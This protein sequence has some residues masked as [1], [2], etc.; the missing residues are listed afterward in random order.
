MSAPAPTSAHAPH[1]E[2]GCERPRKSRGSHP[3]SRGGRALLALLLGGVLW[4]VAAGPASAHATL[5]AADPPDG[6]RLDRSPAQIHLTF[7]EHVSASLGGVRVVDS[8][9]AR[10]DRGAVRA[11]GPDVVVDVQ[12]DLPDGTYV[13]TYR[14]VSADG[15]PVRGSTLFAVGSG[16]VDPSVAARAAAGSSDARWERVG[17]VGRGLAYGGT[18][19]AAGGVLFLVLAHRGGAERQLLRR[20]VWIAAGIGA[21]GA[22]TALPVQAALGTGKGAGALFESGVLGDVTK[23]GV[24][25]ALALCLGG[26]ATASLA[27]DRRRW[28]ALAGAAVAAGSFAATGH[29]RVGSL[30][31][32]ATA[33]DAVHLLVVAAWGG[34]VVFLWLAL[35]A[36]RRSDPSPE[37]TETAAIALRFSSIATA[38]VVA[39][40]A[41]GAF[42]GWDQVRTWH[43]LTS[44]TYGKLLLAKVA[45]VAVVGA[46]GAYNHLRLLPA[47]QQGKARAGL[48]RLRSAARAE[49]AVLVAVVALTGVLV[50][51]TP[52]K[53][54]A[55]GGPVE[56][57][58]QLGDDVGS[59]QLVV[60]PATAGFNQIHLYTFDPEGR[61][62]ELADT[63]DL[64]LSLP[65]AEIG[66]LE[67]TATRAG[68]AHAQLN[69][70]D[71]AVAGRWQITVRIR[72][73]RFTEASGT[74]E[75]PVAG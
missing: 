65:A 23:D 6:A 9:G 2:P 11:S 35:R 29:T 61:P 13:V 59:V 66:P 39:A 73:D 17:D 19:L 60:A 47:L 20:L 51:K 46:L 25:L 62:T 7:S 70:S 16:E 15:H 30:A 50:V 10:Q 75:V 69:G 34:G 55:E 8:S 41:T 12:P 28:L 18:L 48:D 64:E 72:I 63:I 1:R 36:R 33:A 58:I 32:L 49:A 68:P 71:L 43:G 38:G 54:L 31:G 3:G 56:R 27:L 24:G 53:T 52:A 40:G 42:L 44:T 45:C 74:A 67:R 22:I 4:L 5:V 57:I 21:I 37:P 14:I 26:L